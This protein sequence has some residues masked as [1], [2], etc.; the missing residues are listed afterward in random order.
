MAKKDYYNTLGV[1]KEAT[2]A[3]L[4]KAYRKLA[5]KYHPDKNPDNPSAEEKFKE[6]AEAYSVL[7]DPEKRKRYDRFGHRGL[8]GQGFQSEDINLDNIFKQFGN[9]FG[10]RGFGDFFQGQGYQKQGNDLRIKLKVTLQEASKAL[11]KQIKLK[12]YTTCSSCGGNGAKNGTALKV[13]NICHGSGQEKKVSN[14][15][16]IQ[17]FTTQACSQCHGEGKRIET[18]CSDCKGQGR[19]KIEDI[20]DIKLPAGIA[21]GMEFSMTG[22]GNTPIRGGISGDLIIFIEQS[23]DSLLKRDGHNIHYKCYI[24][25]MDAVLGAKVTVPTLEGEVLVKIPSGTQSGHIMKLKDKGLPSLKHRY[26][27]GSQFIHIYVWTPQNLTKQEQEH[28]NT[29]REFKSLQPKPTNK[30]KS[31]FDK[32]KNLF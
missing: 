11:K 10:G 31:F 2:D 14:N 30:D 5:I 9:I 21:H 26:T 3:E 7:S 19:Q 17:M 18:T 32:F 28:I 23:E 24:S 8:E 4:K 27:K 25:F 20:I 16:F 13:C 1:T 29:L 6:A 15:M 12:R 22:K